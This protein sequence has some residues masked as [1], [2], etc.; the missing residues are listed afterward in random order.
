MLYSRLV[1]AESPENSSVL[2][3]C[4]ILNYELFHG[5]MLQ[6]LYAK[7]FGP[8]QKTLEGELS[9]HIL[10]TLICFPACGLFT[11]EMNKIKLTYLS[12]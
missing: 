10:I 5:F 3:T 8:T 7:T 4:I 1:S 6:F 11:S 12:H 9:Y 2:S